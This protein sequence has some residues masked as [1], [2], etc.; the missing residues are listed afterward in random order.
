MTSTRSILDHDIPIT[1][2][3]VQEVATHLGPDWIARVCP[4]DGWGTEKHRVVLAYEGADVT[5]EGLTIT[6]SSGGWHYNGQWR[7]AASIAGIRMNV[8]PKK[9]PAQLARE[10]ERRVLAEAREAYRAKRAKDQALTE[11]VRATNDLAAQLQAMMGQGGVLKPRTQ[12][13]AEAVIWGQGGLPT[14]HVSAEHVSIAHLTLT[15]AQARQFVAMAVT[16][17]RESGGASWSQA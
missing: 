13:S 8:S 3:A 2:R 14:L 12:D 5:L 9:T 4:D 7:F 17:H 15:P 16:W 11:R 6:A 1:W 10:L